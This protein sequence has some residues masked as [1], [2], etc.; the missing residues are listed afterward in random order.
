MGNPVT[1]FE[2]VG[3]D[4]KALQTFY[5]DAFGWGIVPAGPSYAMVHPQADLGINGGVG[6]APEGAGASRVTV[7]IEVDDL[8]AALGKV[9]RLGGRTVMGPLNVPGGPSIALF[10]DPEGHV[11]GLTKATSIRGR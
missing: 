4:A 3:S 11:I 1:H 9:E 8:D 5:K 6:V 7:Y 2:I 10:S